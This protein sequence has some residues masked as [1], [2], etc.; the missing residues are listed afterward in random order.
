MSKINATTLSIGVLGGIAVWVTADVIKVPVW[1]V[2]IAWASFAIVG[3]GALGWQRSVAS[4]LVGIFW[5]SLAVVIGQQQPDSVLLSAVAV[6]ACSSGMVVSSRLEFL[7]LPAIV[8]GF[9]STVATVTV[10]GR[11][12]ASTPFMQNPTVIAAAAMVLGASFG[13]LSEKTAELMTT[14]TPPPNSQEIEHETSALPRWPR[15]P[16]RRPARA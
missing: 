12:I 2:F 15:R 3:G 7:P 16:R 9:A 6:G 5:G 4:N 8:W 11:E 1:V 13:L 10:T 14:P